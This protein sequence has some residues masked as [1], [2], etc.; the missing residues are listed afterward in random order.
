MYWTGQ[1]GLLTNVREDQELEYNTVELTFVC[2]YSLANSVVCCV[3]N[4]VSAIFV[5]LEVHVC[6]PKYRLI[7]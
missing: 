3:H 1:L 2:S 4:I 7:R 6:N 5:V